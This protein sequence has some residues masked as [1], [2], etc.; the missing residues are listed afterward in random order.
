MGRIIQTL[1]HRRKTVLVVA[2]LLTA[3]AALLIPT[4]AVNYD[5]SR[6]LPPDSATRVAADRMEATFGASSEALVMTGPGTYA[7]AVAC[8][9]RLAALPG[10]QSVAFLDDLTDP[11]RPLSEADPTAVGRFWRDGYALFQVTFPSSGYTPETRAALASLREA[12]GEEAA[13]AWSAALTANMI[14]GSEKE[15]LLLILAVIPVFLAILVSFT[16]SFVEAGLF[17]LVT[18]IAVII[19][20]GTNVL[21]GEISF[22]THLS[23]G[24]LQLAIS[25]DYSIF[26][27]HRFNEERLLA[28]DPRAAMALAVRHSLPAVSASALTTA[29]GFLALTAMRYSLGRDIGLVLTKGILL[30]LISVLVL[31]PALTLLCLK[32]IDRTGHRT[33]LPGFRKAGG[34]LLRVRVLLLAAWVLVAGIAWMAQDANRFTYSES[35]ILSGKGSRVAADAQEI[36]ERF[37]PE[38]RVVVLLPDPGPAA[39]AALASELAALPGVRS[40]DSLSMLADP[41][42]PRS[43]LPD[44]LTGAFSADGWARLGV[45]TETGEESAA[46]FAVTDAIRERVETATGGTGL[47]LGATTAIQE[48]REVVE[49]DYGIVTLLSIGAVLAILFLTFRSVI[50]PFVLVLVIESA[51]WINMAVPYFNGT[52]LSFVGYLIVGAI[53]LGATI[54]F[55][56]LL[57]SRYVEARKTVGR[58]DAVREAV[59]NAGGSILTSGGIMAAAGLTVAFVSRIEGIREIG[60]LIGRGS[61]VSA[62]LVLC[63]LPLLLHLLDRPIRATTWA[64]RPS[65]LPTPSTERK[66]LS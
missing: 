27:L 65:H 36:L 10:V 13:I 6:Y 2:L 60:R 62:L 63:V 35:A 4:V 19:N 31:L 56:I 43:L 57:T 54:D 49:Y 45:T 66:D 14:A 16:H 24:V 55:A 42:L 28:P 29:A 33:L 59:R 53:Q 61:A 34:R 5:M 3:A 9:E 23:A 41:T 17:L 12:A 21:F 50:L 20:M 32:G 47:L 11:L 58:N 25:M 26:L 39:E 30:S 37:A 1:L 51:V 15:V 44:R 48:I 38:N 22:M 7:E 18:G 8:K 64:L 40:V 52:A 46:A